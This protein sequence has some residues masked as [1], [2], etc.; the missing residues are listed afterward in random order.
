[1][2][3]LTSHLLVTDW[4]WAKGLMV[5]IGAEEAYDKVVPCDERRGWRRPATRG[6]RCSVT[7][8]E[9]AGGGQRQRD[10]VDLTY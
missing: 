10:R 1:M 3:D 8:G 6:G 7:R 5:H 9:E 4:D 2:I